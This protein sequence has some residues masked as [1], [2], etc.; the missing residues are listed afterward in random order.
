MLHKADH[1]II[2][3]C[4]SANS[5]TFNPFNCFFILNKIYFKPLHSYAVFTLESCIQL[6][7][8]MVS[9]AHQ[10]LT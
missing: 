2:E 1:I 4:L 3:M 7:L 9:R 6:M 5:T 8:L 10:T